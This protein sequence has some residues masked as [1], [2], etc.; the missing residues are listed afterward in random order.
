MLPLRDNVP[1]RTF[2]AVTIG[3]IVA[4]FLVWFWELSSPGVDVHVLTIGRDGV[5]YF[6]IYPA[7]AAASEAGL[8][9]REMEALVLRVQE[10]LGAAA[11]ADRTG[12]SEADVS[13][14][15]DRAFERLSGLAPTEVVP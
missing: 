1:T 6:R 14:T 5:T 15:L 9:D 3:L 12:A 7:D 4:N 8:E 13:A 2:P 10:G 11:I